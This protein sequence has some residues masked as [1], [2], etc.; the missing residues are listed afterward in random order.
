L[1][2]MGMDMDYFQPYAVVSRAQFGTIL[3]RLLFGN[4]YAGGKVYYSNH[5][6]ALKEK[7]ILTQ[8][9]NP[10]ARLE[11]RQWVRLMLMRSAK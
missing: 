10:E 1:G 3:S 7:G 4:T 2:L 8:I 11:L 6:Q 5:L 9:D